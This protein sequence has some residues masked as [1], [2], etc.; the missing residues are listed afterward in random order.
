MLVPRYIASGHAFPQAYSYSYNYSQ[1]I[2]ITEQVLNVS[3][4][5]GKY[6]QN[7]HEVMPVST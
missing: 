4:T 2:A 7:V 3:Y 1:Q 5:C 6:V